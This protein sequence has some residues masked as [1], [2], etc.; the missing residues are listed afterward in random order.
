[1][2]KKAKLFSDE[3]LKTMQSAAY[4]VWDYIGADCLNAV[5]DEKG[6]D[7]NAVTMS[8][9]EVIELSLDAGRFED[10]LADMRRNATRAGRPTVVTDDLMARIAACDYK[11]LIAAVKPAFTYAR[12]GM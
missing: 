3:E 5:A 4:A 12:Y 1:M 6:K 9:A 10:Q 2:A 7:V 11:T 8:R